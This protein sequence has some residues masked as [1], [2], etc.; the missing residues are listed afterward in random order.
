MWPQSSVVVGQDLPVG[1]PPVGLAL[2][3]PL[4]QT[5]AVSPSPAGEDGGRATHRRGEPDRG[6]RLGQARP[7]HHHR[8]WI[9]QRQQIGRQADSVVDIRQ[10][11][12]KREE[13]R[14]QDHRVG[15][16]DQMHQVHLQE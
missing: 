16:I 14:R 9:R 11:H 8:V 12:A 4:N 5:H 13:R 6:D 3:A 2:R 1:Q 15:R 10:V 7:V